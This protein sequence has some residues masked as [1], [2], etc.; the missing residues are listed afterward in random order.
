MARS[1]RFSTRFLPASTPVRVALITVRAAPDVVS[2]TGMLLGSLG[3]RVAIRA[4]EHRVVG[5]IR[6][7]RAANTPGPAVIRGEPCMVECS[8]R[9]AGCR[10]TGL[11]RRR[12]A[13]GRVI[14]VCR[15]FV[16]R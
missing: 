10:V 8:S 1:R 16:I 9:P 5:G 11:A 3:L 15:S 12:E 7:T 14:R 4:G 6:V 2:H 13:G